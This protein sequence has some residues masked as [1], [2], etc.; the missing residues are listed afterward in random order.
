MR[1][2]ARKTYSH[3]FNLTEQELRRIMDTTAQQMQ[4]I[5]PL[6]PPRVRLDVKF[7]NGTIARTSS[8]DDVLSFENMASRQI[9]RLDISVRGRSAAG[10]Y[11]ITLRFTNLKFEDDETRSISYVVRGEERDWVLVTSSELEERIGRIKCLGW[12]GLGSGRRGALALSAIPILA[13]VVSMG[14]MIYSMSRPT[15]VVDVIETRW[16]SGTLRDP[17]EAIIL[18][19]R[20][21]QSRD[22]AMPAM[23]L[24]W[25]VVYPLALV[26][27]LLL[28]SYCAA[29]L[30][31]SYVF[32][33]GDYVKAYDKRLA[34][35]KLVFAGVIGS[36]IISIVAGV[37]VNRTGWG[38]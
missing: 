16:R 25:A 36:L 30:Y 14:G 27:I 24:R 22:A 1:T 5:D 35:R 38:R 6:Q 13:I 31:P 17:I 18:M 26:V 23:F 10:E 34:L 15:T 7:K 9:I 11:A 4:R 8:L 32:N 29:F 3:G 2:E 19:Q 21:S 12:G 37:I 33:W 20:D 28:G